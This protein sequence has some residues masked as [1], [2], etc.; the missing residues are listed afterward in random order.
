MEIV[1][2]DSIPPLAA[3]WDELADRA[4]APP[5]LRPGWAAAWWEAFGTGTLELVGL[6]DGGRLEALAPLVRTGAGL[7]SPTNWHSPGWGLVAVEE[8]ARDELAREL[9]RVRAR[10]LDVSFLFGDEP[11]RGA[12]TRAASDAGFRVLEQTLYQSPYVAVTGP[13]DEFRPQRSST[14]RNVRKRRR[15]LEEEGELEF[16]VVSGGDSLAGQ[17]Q[18]AYA[19]EASGWK[20][21][22]GTAIS[23]SPETLRF[24]EEVARWAAERSWLRLATLRFDG[25]LIAFA[26]NLE[27]GRRLYTL[28]SGYD[29]TMRAHGPGIIMRRDLL[30]HTFTNGLDAYEF[31]GV[32]TDQKLQWTATCHDVHRLQAFASSPAGLARWGAYRFGRPLA[33]AARSRARAAR[34]RLRRG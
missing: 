3:E 17:L 2:C 1:R 27:S 19:I 11:S 20:G 7:R 29:D 22:R 8:S 13:W 30:E 16:A 15:K 5:W 21:E 25:R 4:D 23:S 18:E 31:L 6:R 12:L 32:A 10:Y 24:Y 34:Q 28:K 14:A 9:Y 26:L 33:Q